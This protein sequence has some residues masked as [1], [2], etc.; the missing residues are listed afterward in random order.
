[1]SIFFTF[2]AHT[3]SGA[4]PRIWARQTHTTVVGIICPPGW[5]RVNCNPKFRKGPGLGGLSSR[6]A[7]AIRVKWPLVLPIC[8]YYYWPYL[9]I[10]WPLPSRHWKWCLL[11]RLHSMK[12]PFSSDLSGQSLKPLQ[13]L[14]KVIHLLL[15]RPVLKCK[16]LIRFLFLPFWMSINDVRF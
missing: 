2:I 8:D 11:P 15:S 10:K 3:N 1:M 4:P 7:P 6:G 13:T 14:S 5:N 9:L 12:H 16:Y